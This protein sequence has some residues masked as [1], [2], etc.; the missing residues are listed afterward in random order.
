MNPS[1]VIFHADKTTEHSDTMVDM[2]D[3]ISY[4]EGIEVIDGELSAL[5]H[6][7]TEFDPLEPVEYLMIGITA[8][9]ILSI[10]EPLVDVGSADESRNMSPVLDQN[11]FEPFNL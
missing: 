10:D 6:G 1:L 5:F 2:D 7:S 8:Y 11:G 9:P 3:I 4:V